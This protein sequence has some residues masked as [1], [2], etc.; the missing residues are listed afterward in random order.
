MLAMALA[1]GITTGTASAKPSIAKQAKKLCKKKRGKAKR[2][3]VKKQTKRLKAKA[4]R[5]RLKELNRPGVTV[6]TTQY[7]IPRITADSWRGLG[8]G[9]GWAL[10]R[11]NIC[12]MAE[13]Y[14]TVRGERSKYFGPDGTWMLTGNGI[15]YT[16][17][18]SDFAHKRIIA[19][20]TIPKILKMKPS[21]GPL[22]QVK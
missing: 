20:K 12:S 3:C 18:E 10:A 1:I 4:K 13:I 7:G 22:P 16:N 5:E 6:R 9:Y 15:Q 11:E 17:L 19:D 14:T 21:N 2:K 8:Y